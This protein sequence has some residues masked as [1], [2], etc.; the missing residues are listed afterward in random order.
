MPSNRPFHNFL[1]DMAND[2]TTATSIYDTLTANPAEAPVILGSTPYNLS[3][4]L[5]SVVLTWNNVQYQAAH[6]AEAAAADV[7]DT[8]YPGFAFVAR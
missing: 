3:S 5:Q 4:G 6:A 7:P 8:D 1:V 2:Q